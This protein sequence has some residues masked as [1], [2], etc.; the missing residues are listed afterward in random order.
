MKSN[1]QR[2]FEII[3]LVLTFVFIVF[4]IF[5]AYFYNR[6]ICEGGTL[7]LSISTARIMFYVSIIMAVFALVIHIYQ[8]YLLATYKP[9]MPLED[10]SLEN[11]SNTNVEDYL[12]ETKLERQLM[13]VQPQCSQLTI[14]N[15]QTG[16]NYG[17]SGVNSTVPSRTY[18]VNSAIT[19]RA[20]GVNSAI[21]PRAYGYNTGTILN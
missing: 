6:I 10:I 8:I 21:T 16:I 4:F 13:S 14:P 7:K 20:Y 12:I 19:P 1:S 15:M 17:D 18:G 5:N 9:I 11:I 3:I 2:I